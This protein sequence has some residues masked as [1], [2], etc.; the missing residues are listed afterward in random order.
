MIAWVLFF[1]AF[2]GVGAVPFDT[3]HR[4]VRVTDQGPTNSADLS[5]KENLGIDNGSARIA[6]SLRHVP[7][8]ARVAVAYR[9]GTYQTV[10]SQMICQAAWNAGLRPVEITTDEPELEQRVRAT[11]AVAIFYLDGPPPAWLPTPQVFSSSFSFAQ[12]H[13]R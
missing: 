13:P 8:G 1:I 2:I 4:Q 3:L 11:G 7:A 6:E 9:F 12:L 10:C 5:Y